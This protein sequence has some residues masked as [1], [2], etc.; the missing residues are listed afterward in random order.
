VW[1][2]EHSSLKLVLSSTTWVSGMR[3][4]PS[5]LGQGSLPVEPPYWLALSSF[6]SLLTSYDFYHNIHSVEFNHIC[7]YSL[8]L[9]S[10]CSFNVFFELRNSPSKCYNQPLDLQMGTERFEWGWGISHPGHESRK[11]S[12]QDL[13]QGISKTR[14]F[15]W[16]WGWNSGPCSC[17]T[18]TL[19]LSHTQP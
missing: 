7:T 4:R 1:R 19:H 5:G 14:T 16:C 10:C 9:L 6:K 15:W 18:S 17:Q 2:S 8:I 11:W 3:F 13:E 12:S